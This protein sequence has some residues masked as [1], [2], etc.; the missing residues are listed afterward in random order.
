MS[1]GEMIRAA[2]EARGWSQADLAAYSKTNQSTVDRLESG[3]TKTSKHLNKILNTLGLIERVGMV[4]LV[5]YVRAET[6][7]EAYLY[8]GADPTGDEVPMPPGGTAETVAVEI[9]GVSLGPAF[10]G[11][12]VY[13]DDRREP[14][15]E[16]MLRQLCVVALDD[17]RVLIKRLMRGSTPGLYNLHAANGE[18]IEDARIHWAAVV[19]SISKRPYD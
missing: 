1:M 10:E 19:K 3:E 13:Y 17:G 9:R 4:P 11:W 15:T 16:D 14:P 2:R 7:G 8:D 5:G 18:I 12:L 6:N